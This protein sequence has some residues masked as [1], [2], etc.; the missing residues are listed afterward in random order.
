MK[1]NIL[2]NNELGFGSVIC[3]R[4]G[5]KHLLVDENDERRLEFCELTKGC[6]YEKYQGWYIT[7]LY[8]KDINSSQVT[9]DIQTKCVNLKLVKE[10]LTVEGLG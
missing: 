6:V 4:I 10:V 9:H 2:I 8:F 3:G 1:S 7:D 5:C